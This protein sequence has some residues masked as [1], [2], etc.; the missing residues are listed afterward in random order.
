MTGIDFAI[1]GVVLIS[2]LISVLR[3]FVREALSL[4]SI[5][6]AAIIAGKLHVTFSDLEFLVSIMEHNELRLFV[7][8][9]ILFVLTL[10]AFSLVI[11]FAKKLVVLSGLTPVDR[12]IGLFFGA[13]R[14]IFIVPVLL[15]PTMLYTPLPKSDAWTDSSL[16]PY[17]QPLTIWLIDHTTEQNVRRIL[18]LDR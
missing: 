7:A 6:V 16:V 11:F 9:F 2:C 3:G 13:L 1:I 8:F 18:G 15:I 12:I 10:I 17:F 5:V 14:G 4:A